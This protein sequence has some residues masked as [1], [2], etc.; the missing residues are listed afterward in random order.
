MSC[1][2]DTLF[3]VWMKSGR[4]RLLPEASVGSYIDIRDR[5][6]YHTVLLDWLI[7]YC[8]SILQST[9]PDSYGR[10]TKPCLC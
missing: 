8:D 9:T 1:K 5:P 4:P 10:S 3:G 6:L 7:G 2:H